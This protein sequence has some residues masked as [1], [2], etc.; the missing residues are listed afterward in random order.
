ME[1]VENT[2]NIRNKPQKHRYA[3]MYVIINKIKIT[4]RV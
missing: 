1:Y 3:G 4:A 2:Y